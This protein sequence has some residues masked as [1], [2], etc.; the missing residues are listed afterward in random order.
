MNNDIYV[1]YLIFCSFSELLYC[2]TELMHIHMH[3]SR[4]ACTS[5]Y[6][7]GRMHSSFFIKIH[8]PLFLKNDKDQFICRT[9]G[10]GGLFIKHGCLTIRL[11]Y[12]FVTRDNLCFTQSSFFETLFKLKLTISAYDFGKESLH[13]LHKHFYIFRK[14]KCPWLFVFFNHWLDV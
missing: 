1:N 6:R 4:Q 2:Y 9:W 7:H 12:V 10:G 13:V 14:C 8:E 11:F 3:A 5:I